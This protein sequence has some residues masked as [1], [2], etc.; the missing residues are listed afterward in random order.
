LVQLGHGARQR[1]I[2]TAETERTSAIAEG[3]AGDKDLTKTLLKSCGVPVPEGQVVD[4]AEEA[5]DA[6]CRIGLPVVVK[7]T[8]GNHG[9]GVTLD[10]S[11]REDVLAALAVAEPEGSEVIVERYIRGHEHRLLVVGGRV[12]AADTPEGVVKLRTHTGVALQAVLLR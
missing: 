6:A 12:V 10:L 3:I 8:D 2:W 5:W 7:P 1:R 4:S 11:S 9:R